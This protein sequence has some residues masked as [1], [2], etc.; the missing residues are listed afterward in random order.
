MAKKKQ[1]GKKHKFKYAEPNLTVQAPVSAAAG[2]AMAT[3]TAGASTSARLRPAAGNDRDFGYVF[4]DL[5][6]IVILA[7]I[8]V[9]VELV[10]WYLFS[11]TGL[12]SS[13]YNLVK[14]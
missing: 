10:L 1:S 2:A 11:Y 9:S 5:R 6:R 3:S 12:G 13:I 14:V 8:L 7:A 4:G